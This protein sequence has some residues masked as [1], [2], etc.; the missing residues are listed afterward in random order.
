LSVL[1]HEDLSKANEMN[2]AGLV[3]KCL[4]T[5]SRGHIYTMDVLLPGCLGQAED[6]P[7]G[8]AAKRHVSTKISLD[9]ARLDLFLLSRKIEAQE[10][11]R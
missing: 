3:K 4:F 2:K 10:G 5:A 7:P 1:Q 9:G 11:L 8:M 6:W